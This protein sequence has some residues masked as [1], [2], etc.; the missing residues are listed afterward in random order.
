MKYDQWAASP[1]VSNYMTEHN[2]KN[3]S[4]LQVYF[5]NQMSNFIQNQLHKRMMGWNEVLGLKIHS[6]QKMEDASTA[7]SDKAIIHF[8]QDKME[9]IAFASE[10]GYQVVNSYHSSTY[11]DYIYKE[12]TLKNSYK[13]D[14][15]PKDLKSEY[16]KNIIGLG[17]QMWG[18]WTPTAKEVEYQ[19]FPRI[20]AYAETGWSSQK[21]YSR[22]LKN[23][24]PL[25]QY[26]QSKGYN[27]PQ[28]PE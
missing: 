9:D 1:Q 18:E 25:F 11:L 10:K 5:T 20:A 17:C 15:I 24:A 3:H 6:W 13:F 23:L 12:I 21:D 26:W 27:L 8:W 16:H 28:K 19:T 2:L 4:D 22:F 14:P 7:L